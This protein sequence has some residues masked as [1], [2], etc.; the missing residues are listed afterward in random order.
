MEKINIGGNMNINYNKALYYF[1]YGKYEEGL[2]FLCEAIEESGDVFETI[3]M[4]ACQAE[5]LYELNRFEEAEE[6]IQYVL[7]NSSNYELEKE[8]EWV[9]S[10]Q[11]KI[12][13]D[14]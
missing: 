10:V 12:R 14:K 9:Y 1:E 3:Q 2:K 5:V 4:K 11:R 6:S 13:G 8:I 7:N